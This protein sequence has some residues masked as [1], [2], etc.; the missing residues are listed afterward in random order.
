MFSIPLRAWPCSHALYSS[1]EVSVFASD[2]GRESGRISQEVTMKKF[3]IENSH[4]CK[5]SRLPMEKT[6][7]RWCTF[8][9]HLRLKSLHRRLPEQREKHETIHVSNFIG[10]ASQCP[11]T[12]LVKYRREANHVSSAYFFTKFAPLACWGNFTGVSL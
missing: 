9:H 10:M 2:W 3:K 4:H 11:F 7:P 8:L 6:C 12:G 1:I 5:S